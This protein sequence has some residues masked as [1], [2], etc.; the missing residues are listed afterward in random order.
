MKPW[1]TTL[2]THYAQAVTRLATFW[3]VVRS[4]AQV[5]G[6]ID[7]DQDVT[8]DGLLYRAALGLGATATQQTADLQ[9]GSLDVS[10]FLLASTEAEMEAG[11]WDEAQVT[12]FEAPWD[13]PPETLSPDTCNILSHGRLGATQRQDGRFSAQLHGLLEQ[14]DTSIGRLYMPGC[15]WRLGDSRC[16][17]DLGPWTRT[18][19][20]T[21]VGAD[22]RY[23]FDDTGQ[24]EADGFF[25]E[26]VMTM[27]SGANSGRR[28]DVRTWHPPTFTLH[29]P[30]PYPVAAG[31]TY[32]ALHGDDKT[33]ATCINVFSNAPRYGGY[34]HLPGMDQVLYNPLQQPANQADVS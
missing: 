28:M 14:L 10:A 16:G 30:L 8:I 6:F 23:T 31:D 33:Y 24:G 18:G 27:T 9:P 19:T 32:S 34:P 2:R 1:N 13:V 11:L 25:S 26:G 12:V 7:H 17:V 15:P 5:F 29:R 21:A 20:V 3:K 22:A 4:D